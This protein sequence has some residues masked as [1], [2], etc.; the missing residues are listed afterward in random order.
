MF[1]RNL[2]F[3]CF[4][5]LLV[6]P[7]NSFAQQPE[8]VLPSA[9]SNQMQA[10][11][12]SRNEKMYASGD[13]DG[14]IKI[15]EA[16]TGKLI[17]SLVRKDIYNLAFTPD[18]NSLVITSF[19]PTEV[20]NILTGKSTF[21]GPYKYVNGLD[22]SPDGKW[23][24][25]GGVGCCENNI[26]CIWD[27]KTFKLTDSIQANGSGA[28]VK[29]SNN[30]K[31]LALYGNGP[32]GIWSVERR[33][34][35]TALLGHTN[36]VCDLE[37][38]EN[39]SQ[40]LTASW[41]STARLWDVNS[42][43]QLMVYKGHDN[44]VWNARFLPGGKK[45]IT[46]SS[47]N[48]ARLW[49]KLT[50][51]TVQTINNRDNWIYKARISPDKKTF[52]L[53]DAGGFCSVWDAATCKL[54]FSFRPGKETLNFLNYLKSGNQIVAGN[55]DPV[56][57][58]WNITT[59][60]NEIVYGSHNERFTSIRLS[61]DEK[62]LLT[63]SRDGAV[64]KIDVT[65]G[66]IVFHQLAFLGDW[67]TSADF[68]PDDNLI[69][70]AGGYHESVLFNAD[71]D[72]VDFVNDNT[73]SYESSIKFSPDG[74][75]LLHV[76]DFTV[77]LIRVADNKRLLTI[78][79]ISMFT[80]QRFSPD[81]AYV[82]TG[83]EQKLKIWSV[84]KQQLVRSVD[85]GAKFP[86]NIEMSHDSKYFLCFDNNDSS[87]HV[88]ETLTGKL[89][90][91][92]PGINHATFSPGTD[93]I[94]IVYIDGRVGV[95]DVRGTEETFIVQ[96][97]EFTRNV[98]YYFARNGEILISKSADNI[99]IR[100]LKNGKILKTLTGNEIAYGKSG[101]YLYVLTD[102]M[103]EVYRMPGFN[104]SYRH[105]ITGEKDFLVQDT[106]GRFDGTESARK[107][108]YFVCG[109]EVIEL[110]QAKDQLWV[111][112]LAERIM[113]G[114]AINAKTLEE[115][116]ICS[117]SP[118]VGDAGSSN[119]EY[120]FTIRSRRG[121]LGETVLLVNGIEAR[122][123]KPEQL[124]KNGTFYELLVK[125]EEI[126]SFLVAGKE[127]LVTV[128]AYTADNSISSRGLIVKEDKTKETSAP[129]NLYAVMV[130]VSDYK[131]SELDLKYAA[132]D[133][134]DI[135]NAVSNAAKKLLNADGREHVFMYNLTTAKDHYQLPEKNSIK[136]ILE[137]IGKK[138]MANDILLIFFAG[139]G[140]MTG[141]AGKKQFYFLTADAST[142]STT[143]AVKDVGIS[144]T[145]LVEWMKPQNIKAQKRILI[146]DACNSGQ[147]INDIAGKD[148]VVRND[149][150][151]QQVKAIDKLNEKSG[152]F[153]LSASASNQSAYEM[154]RYSQG[155]LTYSLLK[156]IKQQPD[157]L[158][159]GKY[160]NVSS[161]FNAAEKTVSEISKENGARQEPQI[162]TNTNFNIGLVD[163]E[164]ISN[165]ILPAEK[166]LFAASN[167]QNSDESIA[168]DDLELSKMI[169]LQL[170]D[171]ASRGTDSRIVYVTA[172]NSPDAYS[173][174]GRY[175]IKDNAI[176][177]TVNIKQNKLIKMKFELVG[178]S[179]KPGDLAAAIADKAA[180]LVK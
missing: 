15:W 176:T 90:K 118:E 43:N 22:I 180:W 42:G 104:L 169:N 114:D 139:H 56:L 92:V 76:D 133:A 11:A 73:R 74:K 82:I 13:L 83:G 125:K 60:K 106:L 178:R 30:S 140:V 174:S 75:Y 77:Q 57:S 120:H 143:S 33:K 117:L 55:Y 78:D 122:R 126:K 26:V 18:N 158:E 36:Q 3:Y 111:P 48:T 162:V 46:V 94:Q 29:F 102:D 24:A 67:A 81:G 160:L 8:L 100:D 87:L 84:A 5:F 99:V 124:K 109:T 40:V 28:E 59:R 161:W 66:K 49:D 119:G 61:H 72:H 86:Q 62:Y 35:E 91:T 65:T 47:D 163:Q 64:R 31:T 70:V 1:S 108:L 103:M 173:L 134:T 152:L 115:L 27:A 154:G 157:I 25:T 168:D 141:E 164:V 39:N 98:E 148:L 68:S 37:F 156:A 97:K 96:L 41:D 145:E 89:V 116:N 170:N 131:G 45:I 147:A 50:G 79:S 167:F 142:L 9:N 71:G 105:F 128:K 121:G 32:I 129:P 171:I 85:V 12:I 138:A 2:F 20:Y 63:T 88:W 54:L 17:K 93:S 69:A 51:K 136:K 149:D 150:K 127:N 14:K 155:L 107:L 80:E 137:E 38:S 6:L 159:D 4:C 21:L 144:T 153:I 16:A 165:I 132:K 177:V 10:V 113:K 179:D 44:T 7:G 52:A 135:S 53:S 19:E 123:Y 95:S 101:Q 23:I 110:D 146:F 166:P 112:D 175:T 58:R 130:G 34:L 172:T 151:A